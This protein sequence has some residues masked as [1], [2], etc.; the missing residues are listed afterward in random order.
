MKEQDRNS[1]NYKNSIELKLAQAEEREE[2]LRVQL[3]RNKKEMK[4][5]MVTEGYKMQAQQQQ[6]YKDVEKNYVRDLAA[7]LGID[8]PYQEQVEYGAFI[9]LVRNKVNRLQTKIE[10][11][12]ANREPYNPYEATSQNLNQSN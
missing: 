7:V 4:D 8:M 12:T 2:V 9:E 11:L 5:K 10:M 6:T 1:I 3:M